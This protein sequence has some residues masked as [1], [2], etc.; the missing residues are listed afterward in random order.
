MAAATNPTKEAVIPYL[1]T[2][3]MK[4]DENDTQYTWSQLR[5]QYKGTID[6]ELD[7]F[8]DAYHKFIGK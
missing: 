5:E 3:V 7:T 6:S 4:A 1:Y 2:S 8:N